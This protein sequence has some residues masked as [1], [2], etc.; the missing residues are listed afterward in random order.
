[1]SMITW[2]A[3][4][5]S[6]RAQPQNASGVLDNYFDLPVVNAAQRY[7]RGEEFREVQ[8]LLGRGGG[9][10]VLDLGA[11][12]GIAS[13]ALASIGWRVT[14]L[15]PDPSAEVGAHAVRQLAQDGGVSIDVVEEW[16]ERLPF[17][18]CHFAAVFG[19]Q[20]LHHARDLD[21]MVCEV[22]RVLQPGGL[23][24]FIRDHVANDPSQL[25]AFRAAHPLHSLYGGENAFSLTDYRRAFE[26]AHLLVRHE[27]GPLDSILNYYPGSEDQRRRAGRKLALRLVL[28]RGFAFNRT[29][30]TRWVAWATQH[31]RAPGRLVSFLV[32]KA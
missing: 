9:R 20:V 17:P 6:Y 5:R 24:L 7:A 19:R 32:Q 29:L 13:F 16:G 28:A 26:R 3:A 10:P 18:A 2:E 12:N 4:V 22:A 1:M 14:A 15:E 8:R 11:G 23:A 21:A 25:Q 27:W 31:D 30:H